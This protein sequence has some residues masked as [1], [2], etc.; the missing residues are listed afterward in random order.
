MIGAGIG[1]ITNFMLGRQ[2]TFQVTHHPANGQAVR[3]AVVSGASL[4]LNGLGEHVF[5][6]VLGM[7]YVAARVLTAIIVNIAWNFPLQ[8]NFVFRHAAEPLPESLQ[9]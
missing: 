4:A 2:W 1:A 8:R 3:Y 9:S 6:I 7:Q 5:A